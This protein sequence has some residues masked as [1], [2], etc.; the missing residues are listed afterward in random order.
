MNNL[1]ICFVLIS[2]LALSACSTTTAAISRLNLN[3]RETRSLAFGAVHSTR[4]SMN[5]NSLLKATKDEIKLYESEL[6]SNWGIFDRDSALETLDWLVDEG[7]HI[8]MDENY[9]GYDEILD[10]LKGGKSGLIKAEAELDNELQAYNDVVHILKSNY[11]Y[12]EE[13]INSITTVAAW[14]Y[15]RLVTLA[16]WCYGCDYVT[17][18]EAWGYIDFAAQQGTKSYDG[19]RSY[20]AGVLIGRAIWSEEDGFDSG[21]KKIADQ[22]LNS[23][24]SIYAATEFN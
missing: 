14:D 5:F 12:T 2:A 24:G 13:E 9:Y 7:H 8:S 20:F 16:R 21:N 18:D 4:N 23:Q 11:G 19:W 1:I 3:E 6:E 15:D 10:L 17:A 22:L